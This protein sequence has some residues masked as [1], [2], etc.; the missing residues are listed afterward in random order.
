MKILSPF[1]ASLLLLLLL[2][3]A[4]TQ[5]QTR[6]DSLVPAMSATLK[7]L[8]S[9]DFEGREAGSKGGNLAAE[10]IAS[11]MM[12]AGL[13]PYIQTGKN[14]GIQLFDYYQPFQ[15][16]RYSVVKSSLEISG[17]KG[18]SEYKIQAE[19]N[20]SVED[21]F[22]SISGSYPLVF[23]GYGIQVPSIGYN[24]YS[25]IDVKGKIVLLME[26]YP[27]AGDT[28]SETWKMIRKTAEDDSFD[29]EKRCKLADSLGAIAIIG[30]QEKL[31]KEG[32]RDV[33]SESILSICH[34]NIPYQ[35]A[36][37]IFPD[38][39]PEHDIPC[40][41]PGLNQGISIFRAAGFNS[42]LLKDLY[43]GS[44]IKLSDLKPGKINL[45][46]W[47]KEEKITINNVVGVLKGTDSTH[48]LI[49]GAHYDHLGKRGDLTYYGSDD[50]AS[51][52]TGLLTLMDLFSKSGS[53]PAVN[54]VFGSW[55]AEEKGLIGSES[56]ASKLSNPSEIKLYLNMDMISRSAPEDT[57]ARIISVGTR[58]SD[59]YLRDLANKTNTTL[60]HP[61]TLDLWDVTGHSGSDYASF[62]DKG[63]PVMT[64]FSGFQSEYHT[65]CDVPSKADF[66]KMKDILRMVEGCV[67]GVLKQKILPYNSI[68]D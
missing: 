28:L 24:S 55:T 15:V 68:V 63:I 45:N 49:V 29:I 40:I 5:A 35:D 17:S 23:A 60:I 32:I 2:I 11:R 61:F 38:R 27:G 41:L 26:G 20:Y 4:E 6:Y 12:Q 54:I 59:Q 58:T 48:T 36:E 50:N 66:S 64:F 13:K 31:W 52:T 34:E 65:P 44:N 57:A 3:P 37:F 62:R 21:A 46:L 14:A 1:V 7:L 56:F 43:M 22:E 53:K 67:E 9:P 19:N 33:Y 30:L 18:M 47:V 25:G 8:A 10:Y 51:G 42:A 16:M 39:K